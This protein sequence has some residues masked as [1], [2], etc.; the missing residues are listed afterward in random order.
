[1]VHI[2]NKYISPKETIGNSLTKI[3]GIGQKRSYDV[4][5]AVG[6]ARGARIA[7]ARPTTVT[8]ISREIMSKYEIGSSLKK[9]VYSDIQAL[10]KMRSYRGVRHQNH[11]P[12]RGQRTHTNAQTRKRWS[13]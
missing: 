11:L 9:R 7:L 2:L 13:F 4:C 3:Y 8:E 10:T 1:M 6:V 5:A 12:A